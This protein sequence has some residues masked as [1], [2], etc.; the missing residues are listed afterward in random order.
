VLFFVV[1]EGDL[2]PLFDM[3]TVPEC[4]IQLECGRGP[5]ALS[6]PAMLFIMP[7]GKVAIRVA[8]GEV[9]SL[10]TVPPPLL[11]LLRLLLRLLLLLLL[12]PWD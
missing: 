10:P 9:A 3:K 11:L 8:G 1:L 5:E 7:D 2:E 4:R 6:V 12:V